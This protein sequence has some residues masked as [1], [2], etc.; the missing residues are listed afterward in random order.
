MWILLRIILLY[1]C[2]TTNSNLFP[3]MHYI[4]FYGCILYSKNRAIKSYWHNY[5]LVKAYLIKTTYWQKHVQT[6]CFF[7]ILQGSATVISEVYLNFLMNKQFRCIAFKLSM[8]QDICMSERQFTF[9]CVLHRFGTRE[10][11]C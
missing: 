9:R 6:S 11:H 5:V 3:Y 7:S 4:S 10:I 2:H 8:N 1:I